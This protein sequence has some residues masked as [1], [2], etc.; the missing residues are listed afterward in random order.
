MDLPSNVNYYMFLLLVYSTGW[1]ENYN[2]AKE[3]TY[4]LKKN[5]S[6]RI[7][8]LWSYIN[9]VQEFTRG[10][11]IGVLIDWEVFSEPRRDGRP[12]FLAKTY[13]K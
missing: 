7:I 3:T 1:Y 6:N 12:T 5:H 4:I 9:F 2:I 13:L 11:V 10:V 8:N